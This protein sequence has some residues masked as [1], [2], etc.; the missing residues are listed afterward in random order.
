MEI[1]KVVMD[2][3]KPASAEVEGSGYSVNLFL[4]AGGDHSIC[5][6]QDQGPCRAVCCGAQFFLSKKPQL[7]Y[8]DLLEMILLMAG[9]KISSKG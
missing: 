8:P 1:T 5:L 3:M 2:P 6:L 7:P 4:R 9:V